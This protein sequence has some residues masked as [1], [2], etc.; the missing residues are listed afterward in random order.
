M[1][2][3]RR[4]AIGRLPA[5]WIALGVAALAGGGGGPSAAASAPPAAV[6][7]VI[8]ATP[9]DPAPWISDAA[10]CARATAPASTF[11]IPHALVALQQGVITTATSLPWDGTAY[12]VAVWRRAH[13]VDSAI[14]WSALPFFQQTARRLGRER[15]RAGLAALGY[16]ADDFT[17]DIASFWLNGDLVVTPLEQFAFLRRFVEGRLPIDRPHLDTV[18]AALTMPDGV[19]TNAGGEH[20]FVLA[21]PRPVTVR[22]KTG[23]TTVEGERVSWAVGSV[24]SGER[25]HVVV[26]RV[27]ADG[28][29]DGTAGLTAARRALDAL[30]GGPRR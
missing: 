30:P 14:R 22:L 19:V 3:T 17:G 4:M 25:E 20:P 28:P 7:C 27:R 15:M 29:L 11:K 16:A 10:E 5:A 21:W 1:A 24:A 13:T 9:S 6:D 23:N 8:I 18:R 12:E 26:A 2:M